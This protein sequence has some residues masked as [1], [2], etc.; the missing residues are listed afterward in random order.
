MVLGGV[1]LAVVGLVA[2]LF[3]VWANRDDGDESSTELA[4]CAEEDSD[5]VDLP[6]VDD[7]FTDVAI[8]A[9]TGLVEITGAR[10]RED[11]VGSLVVVDFNIQ[12]VTDD[13]PSSDQDEFYYSYDLFEALVVDGVAHDAIECQD[14]T[15]ERQLEP[16]RRVVAHIGYLADGDP[17]GVPI[18]L[19]VVDGGGNV[20]VSDG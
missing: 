2:G 20:P 10:A 1:S 18:S 13:D 6:V 17:I 14:S 11:D 12:N 8:Y 15:G 3:A 4:P 9:W 19:D 16:G 7:P 5:W